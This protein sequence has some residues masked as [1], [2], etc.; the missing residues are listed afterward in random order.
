MQLERAQMRLRLSLTGREG[1]KVK[2]MLCSKM[3]HV[4]KDEWD[5]GSLEI[6]SI[7]AI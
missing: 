4:E 1:R 7:K 6:V 3:A 5:D 2:E